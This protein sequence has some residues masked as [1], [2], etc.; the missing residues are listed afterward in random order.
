M[1]Y[2]SPSALAALGLRRLG[3]DVLVSDKAVLH[4]AA[5]MAFGDR[6]RIDDFCVLSGRVELGRNVHLAV[7]CNIAGGT[8]GVELDDFAGLAYGCHVFSQSDDYSGASLTNP[9]VPQRFKRETRA[10]VRIGRHCIVGASSVVFPGVELGEGCA[11]G[12][13]SLVT[14]STEPWSVYLGIPARRKGARRQDLLQLEQ[15][16]LASIDPTPCR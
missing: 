6:C 8:E 12:A 1:A 4:G 10:R 14:R 2:L 13:M 9:T 7:F 15:D 5:Q 11:V 16:Y 3:R